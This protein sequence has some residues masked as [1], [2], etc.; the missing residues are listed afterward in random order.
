VG[1]LDE[2]ANLGGKVAAVVGGAA[3]VG[4]A[5][6]LALA[7]AG[8]DVAF[9]DVRADAVDST[10][11]EVERLGRRVSGSVADA[12]EPDQL[13]GFYE[14]FDGAF[15]RLDIV[16]NVAGRADRGLFADATKD[17]W[18]GDIHRNFGWV[19]ESMSYA[20][21]RIRAGGRGG[22]II[23]FTTIEAGRGAASF[24]AYAGA[25]AGL[26]NFSRAVANELGPEGIRV[27]MVAPDTTRSEAMQPEQ[28]MRGLGAESPEQ[29][30]KAFAAYIPLGAPPP[31]EALGDAVLFLASDL[32]ASI[33]GTTLHVDGGTW[34]ASGFL[35]WP[36][37]R[38]WGPVPTARIFHDEP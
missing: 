28:A 7:K 25:K 34:A 16:V 12:Y 37:E 13:A 33:T 32:S 10:R 26:T 15:T 19:L 18:T 22:S 6:T 30:A 4:A 27:N 38:G 3:G 2:R 1:H 17:Q 14:R 35:R 5:V 21:P 20:I 11:Q 8:V 23:N 31:P 36:D 9:C 24:A 29:M